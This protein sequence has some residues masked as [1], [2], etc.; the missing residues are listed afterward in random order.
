MDYQKLKQEFWDKGYLYLENF[1]E[2]AVMDECYI[3]IQ[4]HFNMNP[5][6]QHD[7]EFLTRSEA[8]VIPWFPSKNN[9][10]D[11]EA[12]DQLGQNAA[13]GELTQYVLGDDWRSLECMV[14]FSN[15]NSKGQPWHQDCPPEQAEKFNLNRLIYTSD[16]NEK[17]GG[18]TL[19]VEGSHKMGLLPASQN[20]QTFENEVCLSPT[21]GSLLLIHGHAWHR[22]LPVGTEF[23]VSTNFRCVPK[24]TPDNVTDICVYADMRYQFST[25][26]VLETRYEF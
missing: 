14:M 13:L 25:K 21:K 26:Q 1:F 9:S 19:V 15:P 23:R 12:F 18:Q 3:E 6:Y 16:I 2:Q 5:D 17:T 7:Q 24:N 10:S 8:D 4:K 20:N 11:G 22:V